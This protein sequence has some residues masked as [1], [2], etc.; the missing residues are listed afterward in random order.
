[1]KQYW[2]DDDINAVCWLAEGVARHRREMVI[3]WLEELPTMW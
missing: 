1:M 3:L 2:R